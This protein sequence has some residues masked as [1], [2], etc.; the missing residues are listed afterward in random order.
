MLLNIPLMVIIPLILILT[1]VNLI[2]KDNKQATKEAL[3]YEIEQENK[4]AANRKAA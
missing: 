1:Y 3:L 2:L 4:K